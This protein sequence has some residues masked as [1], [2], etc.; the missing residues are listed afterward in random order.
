MTGRIWIKF[1]S[2]TNSSKIFSNGAWT[3][4]STYHTTRQKLEQVARGHVS[5]EYPSELLEKAPKVGTQSGTTEEHLNQTGPT[6]IP[7]GSQ[8]E[9]QS[10]SPVASHHSGTNRLV[11]RSHHSSHSQVDSRRRQGYK[12]KKRPLSTKGREIK[13]Q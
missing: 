11:A 2:S 13:T 9:D 1:L 3:R 5:E 6:Q 12:G 7:S 4:G 10:S 8:G